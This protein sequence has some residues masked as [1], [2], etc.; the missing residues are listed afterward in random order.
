MCCTR[1]CCGISCESELYEQAKECRRI[2]VD[3]FNQLF[4]KYDAIYCP[5]AT[6]GAPK[7]D[8]V[9]DELGDEFLIAENYLAYANFGGYPSIT[10]PIGFDNGFV[11]Y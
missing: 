8:K 1:F 7:A 2:I 11:K 10:L 3:T 5:A 6:G 4:K 9:F